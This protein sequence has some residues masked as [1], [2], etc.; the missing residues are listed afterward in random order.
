MSK[1]HLCILELY[2]NKYMLIYDLSMF[3][4]PDMGI[5]NHPE[6]GISHTFL[7]PATKVSQRAYIV[8]YVRLNYATVVLNTH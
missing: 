1:E 7:V 2:V 3:F 4:E 5:S 6:I 8:F